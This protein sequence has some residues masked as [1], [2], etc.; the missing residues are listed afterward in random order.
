MTLSKIPKAE[1]IN[2]CS[3]PKRTQFRDLLSSPENLRREH[4]TSRHKPWPGAPSS[5][6]ST[7]RNPA[8]ARTNRGPRRT[9]R[10]IASHTDALAW[11]TFRAPRTQGSV[12]AAGGTGRHVWPRPRN[13][14]HRQN[15]NKS[16]HQPRSR[17]NAAVS[18][19]CVRL[20]FLWV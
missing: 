16:S 14:G 15:H 18:I 17:K 20:A 5:K 19:E 11:F 13:A 3:P 12:R 6:R 4:K 8:R 1:L 7:R 2:T 9:V 10:P